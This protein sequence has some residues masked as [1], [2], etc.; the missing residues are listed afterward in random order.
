MREKLIELLK[1]IEGV[2]PKE[3]SCQN[4]EYDDMGNC[5]FYAKADYLIANDVVPVV[6]CKGCRWFNKEGYE[7]DNE[8]EEDS[9]LH[10]GFCLHWRR[11]TQA[12]RFCS[13][14]ERRDNG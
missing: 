1:E 3:E 10:M 2:C 14:G 11:G 4:C 9:A 13:Y 7:E 8:H 12:C 5:S 6:R